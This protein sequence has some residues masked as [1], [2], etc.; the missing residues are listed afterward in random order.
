MRKRTKNFIVIGSGFTSL[1]STLSLIKKGYLPTVLDI[2][3][4]YTK[5]DG[6]SSISKPFFYKKKIED[7]SLFGGLS[8]VWKGVVA[9]SS[10]SDLNDLFLKN[11]EKLL[12]TTLNL[13]KDY[14]FYTNTTVNDK[15]S[16]FDF[17]KL[18][19]NE[20]KNILFRRK[21]WIGKPIFFCK[22]SKG[23]KEI[24]PFETKSFFNN[25]IKTKKIKYIKG[26][27]IKISKK[28]NETFLVYKSK[29]NQIKRLKY[30]YIFCG[31]GA[32]STNRIINNS[33]NSIQNL[34]FMN[35]NKKGLFLSLF[36]KKIIIDLNNSHPVFQGIIFENNKAK[37]YIQC[38][39]FSQMLYNFV[40][41][42]FKTFFKIILSLNIFKYLSIIFISVDHNSEVEIGS[43][44][45]IKTFKNILK[46]NMLKK[47]FHKINILQNYFT[48]YSL[49]KY[50]PSLA[51]NHY[52]A[53][54]SFK[55][56]NLKKKIPLS[57]NIGKVHGLKNFYIVDSASLNKM[58]CV[59]PTLL[60]MMHS[61][62]IT[63][64]I[65]NKNK[66]I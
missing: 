13:I 42:F 23:K 1:V 8:E 21:S 27:A 9:G 40:P 20:V 19:V 26:Q 62:R 18:N 10:N 46:K 16:K 3:S 54:F 49:G 4:N 44:S 12:D 52:G 38:Y 55:K 17:V 32:L 11:K 53:N 66:N 14:S 22:K 63:N 51:G 48:I 45:N 57:N 31:A 61:C 2:G 6:Y 58:L 59:P 15:K 33:L 43:N 65:I 50:L 7:Y 60:S 29:N 47:L 56:S 41:K 36:R 37:I 64:N 39:L 28:K 30:N 34:V 35:T 25:L 5:I 24:I